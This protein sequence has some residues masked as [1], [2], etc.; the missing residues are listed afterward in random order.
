MQEARR[1]DNSDQEV[2]VKKFLEAAYLHPSI[3]LAVIASDGEEEP[4][5]K[6]GTTPGEGLEDIDS[7]K[8]KN[9]PAPSSGPED[10]PSDSQRSEVPGNDIN[11]VP[12]RPSSNGDVLCHTSPYSHTASRRTHRRVSSSASSSYRSSNRLPTGDSPT[13]F[14]ANGSLSS[15][16]TSRGSSQRVQLEGYSSL[17]ADGSFSHSYDPIQSSSFRGL[18]GVDRDKEKSTSNSGAQGYE[19][20]AVLPTGAEDDSLQG[21]PLTPGGNRVLPKGMGPLGHEEP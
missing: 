18:D 7:E 2:D 13:Y 3:K 12:L 6:Y 10:V 5:I 14:D 1:K 15:P 19:G 20:D 17:P 9:G 11:L 16:S 8:I 21:V 4:V